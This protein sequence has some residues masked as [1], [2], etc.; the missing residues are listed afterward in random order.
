MTQI[1]QLRLNPNGIEAIEALLAQLRDTVL[2]SRCSCTACQLEHDQ[3]GILWRGHQAC[4][5]DRWLSGVATG[6]ELNGQCQ[7]LN[8]HGSLTSST[9]HVRMVTIVTLLDQVRAGAS[10]AVL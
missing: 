5:R 10:A 8:Y 9:S 2:R 3:R 6:R 1:T 4:D 7:Q